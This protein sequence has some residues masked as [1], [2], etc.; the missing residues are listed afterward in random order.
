MFLPL[1][2][3]FDCRTVRWQV[4]KGGRAVTAALASRIARFS[5]TTTTGFVFLLCG[6]TGLLLVLF[7]FIRLIRHDWLLFGLSVRKVKIEVRVVAP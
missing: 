3:A 6:R 4:K 2:S 5:A 1:A 7:R